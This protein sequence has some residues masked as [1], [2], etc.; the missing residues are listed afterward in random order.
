MRCG[1]GGAHVLNEERVAVSDLCER[2]DADNG[3]AAGGAVRAAARQCHHGAC[4]AGRLVNF[5]PSARH[6][7]C[8]RLLDEPFAHEVVEDGLVVEPRLGADALHALR[9][10]A[11]ELPRGRRAAQVEDTGVEVGAEALA[12]PV[13]EPL[14]SERG[15]ERAAVSCEP[16]C[17]Q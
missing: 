12:A 10:H 9:P 7:A 14:E 16:P 8:G 2:Q 4:T 6:A 1:G 3:D 5:V 13:G 15:S 17:S 11:H